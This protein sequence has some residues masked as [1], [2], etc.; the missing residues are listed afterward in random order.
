MPWFVTLFADVWDISKVH[1]VWDVILSVGSS[2]FLLFLGVAIL[3]ALKLD[4]L[5]GG[6]RR[7]ERR[8]PATGI[9]DG[10]FF[11]AEQWRTVDQCSVVHLKAL[12]MWSQTPAALIMV[13][14]QSAEE[15]E[16]QQTL[17][18]DGDGDGDGDTLDDR[19]PDGPL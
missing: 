12:A 7:S 11:Q 6:M 8:A 4:L 2:D 15:G 18:G 16:A 13:H 1:Y 3:R 5:P 19:V 10:D 14:V 9:Y 17:V